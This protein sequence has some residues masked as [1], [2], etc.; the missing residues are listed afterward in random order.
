MV[1]Q[2]HTLHA[3]M[4]IEVICIAVRSS[5]DD[6]LRPHIITTSERGHDFVRLVT[7]S[8]LSSFAVQFEGFCVSGAE[9][10]SMYF[11][12]WQLTAYSDFL[13]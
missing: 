5:V 9:G 1:S 11:T 7:K 8:E 2:I 3:H 6:Y 10:M 4:G 12:N 13:S